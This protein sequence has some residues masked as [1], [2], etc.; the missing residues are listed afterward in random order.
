MPDERPTPNCGKEFFSIFPTKWSA[1]PGDESLYGLHEVFG[2]CVAITHRTGDSPYDRIG[3]IN[4]IKDE[5]IFVGLY[6]SLE[7]RIR[8]VNRIIHPD[9]VSQFAQFTTLLPSQQQPYEKLNWTHSDHIPVIVGPAHFHSTASPERS[10]TGIMMRTYFSGAPRL[11]H[12]GTIDQQ[13]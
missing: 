4:F 12:I 6:K 10:P 9:Y 2:V 11:H 3:E 13:D 1:A 8:E 7:E 5:D